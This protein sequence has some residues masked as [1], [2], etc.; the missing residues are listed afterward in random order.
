MR[1]KREVNAV[2]ILVEFH[3][4]HIHLQQISVQKNGREEWERA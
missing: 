2:F 4:Q 3:I 1:S